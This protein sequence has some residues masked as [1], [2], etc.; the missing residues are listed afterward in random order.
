MKKSWMH[1]FIGRI[2]SFMRQVMLYS[3]HLENL[4]RSS[5][6]VSSSVS[7]PRYLRS[8]FGNKRSRVCMDS[9]SRRGGLGKIWLMSHSIYPMRVLDHFRSSVAWVRMRMTGEISSRC[10]IC[11]PTTILWHWSSTMVGWDLW[12]SHFSSAQRWSQESI[13]HKIFWLHIIF[14]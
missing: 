4:W 1:F 14:L 7:S 10:S 9:Y 11:S 13:F 2:S 3:C 6:G 8:Y 5:E 12:Y